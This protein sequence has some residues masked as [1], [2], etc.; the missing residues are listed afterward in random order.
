M[1][2]LL[3]QSLQ[4]YSSTG[5]S[6]AELITIISAMRSTGKLSEESTVRAV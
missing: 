3:H 2:S 5:T 1:L 4:V 6:M